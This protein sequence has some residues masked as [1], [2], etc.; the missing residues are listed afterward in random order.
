MGPLYSQ[1]ALEP[2]HATAEVLRDAVTTV[3]GDVGYRSRV[4]RMQKAARDAGGYLRAADAI[5]QFGYQRSEG[6]TKE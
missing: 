5:Q 6:K 4:A 2:E 1:T 3:V